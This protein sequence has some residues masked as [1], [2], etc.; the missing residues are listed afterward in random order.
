MAS[1]AV[2]GTKETMLKCHGFVHKNLKAE[3][4]PSFNIFEQLLGAKTIIYTETNTLY[5]SV[6]PIIV[7]LG[8]KICWNQVIL[9]H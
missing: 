5:Y 9:V 4:A 8:Y 6:I 2:R 3:V 1:S 7:S